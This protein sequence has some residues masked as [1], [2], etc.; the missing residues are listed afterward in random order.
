MS[1]CE[2]EPAHHRM[3][4]VYSYPK[5]KANNESLVWSRFEENKLNCNELL[6]VVMHVLRLFIFHRVNK[7][8][9]GPFT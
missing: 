8:S 6:P 7:R 3:P 9:R 1:G 4:F 2:P 5:I